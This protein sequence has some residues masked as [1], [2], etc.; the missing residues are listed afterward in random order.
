MAKVCPLKGCSSTPGMC[1][2]DRIML[3]VAVVIVL[4][5]IA[6]LLNLF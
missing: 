6:K 1:M 4:V 3:V 2:H 5:V